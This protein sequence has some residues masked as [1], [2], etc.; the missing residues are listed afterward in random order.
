V[1]ALVALLLVLSGVAGASVAVGGTGDR[2]RNATAALPTRSSTTGSDLQVAETVCDFDGRDV[3]AQNVA[4]T[5][6]TV[7]VAG[8]PP[9]EGDTLTVRFTLENVGQQTFVFGQSVGAFAVVDSADGQVRFG[10]GANGRQLPPGGSYT[11]EA[12]Y[13]F[14]SGEAG[15]VEVWPGFADANG[16]TSP[17]P[18]HPCQFTVEPADDAPPSV[19]VDVQPEPPVDDDE[20]VT[21]TATADDESEIDQLTIVYDGGVVATCEETPCAVELGTLSAGTHEVW[22]SARDEAGNVGDSDQREFEVLEPPEEAPAVRV[23]TAHLVEL[24]NGTPHLYIGA[25]ATSDAAEISSTTIVL[26]GEPVTT[27]DGPNCAYET[28]DEGDDEHTYYATGVDELGNSGSSLDASDAGT[29]LEPPVHVDLDESVR[30]SLPPSIRFSA[31]TETDTFD[32]T[33][34]VTFTVSDPE[35]VDRIEWKP[36]EWGYEE[37][38]VCA[39][40]STD[41]DRTER[42]YSETV[43]LDPGYNSFAVRAWDTDGNRG[44]A[45]R[46]IYLI[47]PEHEYYSVEIAADPVDPEPGEPV[48]LTAT[49]SSVH[50]VDTLTGLRIHRAAFFGGDVLATCEPGGRRAEIVCETTFTPEPGPRIVPVYATADAVGESGLR[51]ETRYLLF[52]D[53]EDADDDGLT[54]LGEAMLCTAPDDPDT[55]RDG[56]LDSWEVEGLQYPD[57]HVVDL[58]AQGADPC[59]P[60]VFLEIDWWQS[61]DHTHAPGT[62]AM[63]TLLN[64]YRSGGVNLHVDLDEANPHNVSEVAPPYT[65]PYYYNSG[66]EYKLRKEQHFDPHRLRTHYYASIRHRTGNSAYIYANSINI[67]GVADWPDWLLASEIF[68]ELGHAVGLGHGGRIG[69]KTAGTRIRGGDVVTHAGKWDDEN[70]KPNYLSSMNYAHMDDVYWNAKNEWMVRVN[71]YSREALP[72]LDE[73]HLD[74]RPTGEFATALQTYPLP[75]SWSGEGDW[76]PVVKYGCTAPHP[77]V[78][79]FTVPVAVASNGTHSVAHRYAGEGWQ[80]G[81]VTDHPPG[82]DW[83]CDGRIE[84]DVRANVDGGPDGLMD[85]SGDDADV[86]V[87]REDWSRIPVRHPCPSDQQTERKSGTVTVPA[88]PA[89]S[90]AYLERGHDPPC[91]DYDVGPLETGHVPITALHPLP[92]ES[93]DGLDNDVDGAVDEGCPDSDEDGLPDAV[94]NCPEVAN[95]EQRDS[96]ADYVGDACDGPLPPPAGF[97]ATQ[98]GGSVTLSWSPVDQAA[99][100][101][102]HRRLENGS[103]RYLGDYPSATTTEFVDTSAPATGE[104]EYVVR[105]LNPMTGSRGEPAGAVLSRADTGPAGVFD[106]GWPTTAVVGLFAIL[107]ALAAGAFLRR[108]WR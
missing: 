4:L 104:V 9:Q 75:G 51:S 20:S 98:S 29:D 63:T 52:D 42:S 27:C 100:Y 91:I 65:G 25:R 103:I 101:V 33:A 97:E 32:S 64:A 54:D 78:P 81:G 43:E 12:T 68:H 10:D 66:Y 79:F 24:V 82:I 61:D 77:D 99:G 94:D 73:R 18:W 49:A 89:P 28:A 86:H 85:T 7:S 30:D 55:D 6:L 90:D 87:G 57:G 67:M 16:Q 13:R 45:V 35:G 22:A 105:A 96:D 19:S 36:D 3:T 41:C 53:G 39:D 60:D 72:D 107:V 46:S 58:P 26:D 95:P 92:A 8:D 56:L 47:D 106:A 88:E 38:P 76:D 11:H 5:S 44:L 62:K 83:N 31:P 21:V 102:V 34:E 2:D 74:E 50:D 69:A 1:P 40:G 59:S 71:D 48:T 70:W 14:G 37:I 17:S 23:E 80:S 15:N 84:A 93:C 108:R